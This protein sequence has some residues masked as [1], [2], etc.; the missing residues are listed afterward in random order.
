[1]TA[2]RQNRLASLINFIMKADIY[3][4][5]ILQVINFFGFLQMLIRDIMDGSFRNLVVKNISE[6]FNNAL[7]R[8]SANK[9][10]CQHNLTKPFPCDGYIK[11]HIII[12]IIR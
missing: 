3:L 5:K 7:I 12:F 10:Q 6:E 1:M 11:E 9:K 4:R 8:A 2:T